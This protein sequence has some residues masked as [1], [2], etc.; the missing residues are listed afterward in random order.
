MRSFAMC[1]TCAREYGT[2]SASAFSRAAERVS[3]T[4]GP[5]LTFSTAAGEQPVLAEAALVRPR[6]AELRAGKIIAVKGVGGFHLMC[7]ATDEAVV[8]QLRRRKHR[9]E[10]PLAVMFPLLAALEAVAEVPDERARVAAIAPGA[11]RARAKAAGADLA[12]SVAPGNPWIG[13][14]LPYAPVHVLPLELCRSAARW[15]PVPIW[16]RSRCA[17]MIARR[18]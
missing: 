7:D 9:D 11:G 12:P 3:G 5:R 15:R 4:A 17:P 6:A 2:P 10:K 8:V 13:A 1:P 16:P 14:L 18:G